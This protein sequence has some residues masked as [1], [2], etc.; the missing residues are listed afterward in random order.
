M[1]RV[2]NEE[3]AD[4]CTLHRHFHRHLHIAQTLSQTLAY[5][6]DTFTDTCIL[7][8]H[9]NTYTLHSRHSN[10]FL[11]LKIQHFEPAIRLIVFDMSSVI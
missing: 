3:G 10:T 4:T 1:G 6:T 9:S 7:H 11:E 8:R 5:C 2:N